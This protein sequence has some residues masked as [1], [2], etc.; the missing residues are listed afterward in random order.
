MA[1]KLQREVLDPDPYYQT[2]EAAADAVGAARKEIIRLADDNRHL[3]Q[4]LREANEL[5][6]VLGLLSMS[7]LVVALFLA[8]SC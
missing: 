5:T 6:A 1:S 4:R 8:E 7:L 2:P 3:R